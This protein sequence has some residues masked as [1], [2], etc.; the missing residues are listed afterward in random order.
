MRC[1]PRQSLI[2]QP[3]LAV[4]PL[5][6]AGVTSHNLE[7]LVPRGCLP[8]QA[9][10]TNRVSMPPALLPLGQTTN[11]RVPST[12]PSLTRTTHVHPLTRGHGSEPP[13]QRGSGHP[14]R[15]PPCYAEVPQPSLRPREV[16]LSFHPLNSLSSHLPRGPVLFNNSKTLFSKRPQG[17]RAPPTTTEQNRL[18][19][20]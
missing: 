13:V 17:C 15:A 9:P 19:E 5:P 2:L 3:H 8:H 10:D 12:P 14:P 20:M 16:E 7:G 1:L 18:N 6:G 4:L 11:S